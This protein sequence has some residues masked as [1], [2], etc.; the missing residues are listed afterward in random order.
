MEVSMKPYRWAIALALP[1]LLLAG[2]AHS[3]KAGQSPPSRSA[4]TSQAQPAQEQKASATKHVPSYTEDLLRLTEANTN[5]RR[6]LFTGQRSQL[7]VMSIPPSES[8]GSEKHPHVEQTIYIASGTGQVVLDGKRTNVGGGDVIVVTPGTQ[9]NLV[10]TGTTP[11]QVF[12]TYVP[13]N[14]IDGRV[15]KTKQDAEQDAQDQGFGQQIE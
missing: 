1:A 5:Y 9:H 14:H 15:H 8:I 6:V 7:V 2:L 12:T 13:P 4:K 3:Q 11:L 10:N